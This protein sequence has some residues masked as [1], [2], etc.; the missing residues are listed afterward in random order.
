MMVRHYFD[1]HMGG[2]MSG[3][4]VNIGHASNACFVLG[5]HSILNLVTFVQSIHKL[6]LILKQAA[7]HLTFQR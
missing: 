5:T 1:Q 4:I 3:A 6:D 7:R 2:P